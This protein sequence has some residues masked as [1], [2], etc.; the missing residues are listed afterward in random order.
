MPRDRW[1]TQN[2]FNDI[3]LDF[4]SNIALFEHFFLFIF[5]YMFWFLIL[6]GCVC[7]FLFGVLFSCLL[8]K[9]RENESLWSLVG[10]EVGWIWKD[11]EMG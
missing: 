1:S 7:V 2:E 10:G 11:L 9:E 3:F 5:C 6:W 8:F 4:L